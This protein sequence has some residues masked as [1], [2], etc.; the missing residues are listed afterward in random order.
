MGGAIP[1]PISP[2]DKSNK[3]WQFVSQ[4]VSFMD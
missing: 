3:F 2:G 1:E 4:N